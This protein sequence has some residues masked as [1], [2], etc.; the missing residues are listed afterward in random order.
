MALVLLV[1]ISFIVVTPITWGVVK[2]VTDPTGLQEAVHVKLAPVTSGTRVTLN[3]LAEQIGVGAG[4][5]RWGVGFTVTMK[6]VVWPLHPFAL[7]TI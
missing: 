4:F 6:L 1:S 7:G 2:P 3:V 5:A